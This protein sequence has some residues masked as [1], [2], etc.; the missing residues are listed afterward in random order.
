MRVQRHQT[1]LCAMTNGARHGT[2]SGTT[3]RFGGQSESGP[4]KSFQPR[5]PHGKRLTA[6]TSD[7]PKQKTGTRCVA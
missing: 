2:T 5:R 4:S 6:L 1:G 3:A 7:N